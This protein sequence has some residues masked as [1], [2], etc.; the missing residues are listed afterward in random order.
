MTFP[1]PGLTRA[2]ELLD[3]GHKLFAK[4][5]LVAQRRR[6]DLERAT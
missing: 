3:R 6:K 2:V 1:E 4:G 5:P